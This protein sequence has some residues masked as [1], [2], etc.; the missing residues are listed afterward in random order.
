MGIEKYK[1]KST[2]EGAKLNT[3]HA[4]IL[5]LIHY[6]G[7]FIHESGWLALVRRGFFIY[8][9]PFLFTDNPWIAN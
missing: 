8:F 2:A 3:R 4:S 6:F 5:G 1:R 7:R 9:Y